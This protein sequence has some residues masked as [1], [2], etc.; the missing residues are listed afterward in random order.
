MPFG[1][2]RSGK[3]T[4]NDII[5]WEEVREKRAVLEANRQY[6]PTTTFLSRLDFYD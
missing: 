1:H 5:R 2:D 4:E 6:D 3:A